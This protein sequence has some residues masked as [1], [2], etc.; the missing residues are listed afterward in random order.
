MKVKQAEDIVSVGYRTI[1]GWGASATLAAAAVER[2]LDG[3]HTQ[4]ALGAAIMA[5]ATL[6]VTMIGGY[7]QAVAKINATAVP[8]AVVPVAAGDK[9]T[10][11]KPPTF[12]AADFAADF[13]TT[14][15]TVPAPPASHSNGPG[16][17]EP[18]PP[19]EAADEAA[20]MDG[21][22]RATPLTAGLEPIPAPTVADTNEQGGQE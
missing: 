1:A 22:D 18:D 7:A 9:V 19:D 17:D 5:V 6:M 8:A 12:T 14:A 11:L 2:V 15:E 16:G 20:D 21:A 10:V 4:Q 13:T 3:D